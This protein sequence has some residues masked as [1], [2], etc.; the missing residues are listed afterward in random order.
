MITLLNFPFFLVGILAIAIPILL[1]LLMRGRPRKEIFPAFRLIKKTERR[2]KRRLNLRHYLLLTLRGLLFLLL[3]LLLARPALRLIGGS[4]P[5]REEGPGVPTR[6]GSVAAVLVFDTSPRTA[7]RQDN[8]SRLEEAKSFASEILT[9]LPAESRAAVLTSVG[10]TDFFQVDLLAAR[11]QIEFLKSGPEKRR[12]IESVTEGLTLL[13]SVGEANRELFIF[14]DRTAPGWDKELR[15]ELKRLLQKEESGLDCYLIDVAPSRSEDVGLE[16]V[17]P[18][19]GADGEKGNLQL[20]LDLVG[21][22]EEQEGL[23]TLYL[24]RPE[25]ENGEEREGTNAESGKGEGF[26]KEMSGSTDGI[27][28]EIFQRAEKRLTKAFSFRTEEGNDSSV[29]G[30]GEERSRVRRQTISFHL[31]GLDAGFYQGFFQKTPPDNLGENDRIWFTASIHSEN[32]VLLVTPEPVDQKALFFRE[33][34]AP[35]ELRRTGMAPYEVV[36][37]SFQDFRESDFDLTPYRAV[38]FLDVPPLSPSDWKKVARFTERG[39]GVGFFLGRNAS[40]SEGFDQ[41]DALDLLGGRPIRQVR[42]PSGGGRLV[43]VA[44]EHPILSP[45][46]SQQAVMNLPW[47]ELPIFR[48]WRMEWN[49]EDRPV[50]ILRFADRTESEEGDGEED[51]DMRSILAVRPYGEGMVVI[52][53]TPFSDAP[54]D[55][56]RWNQWTTGDA[57]WV[58]LVLADGIVRTLLFGGDGKTD[59]FPFEIMTYRPNKRDIPETVTVVVPDGRRIPIQ[60]D[61]EGRV[62]FVG[63]GAVGPYR[64]L[65]EKDG[66]GRVDGNRE[67]READARPGQRTD[68]GWTVNYRPGDFDPTLIPREEILALFDPSSAVFLQSPDDLEFDATRRGRGID[69]VPL[70]ALLLVIVFAAEMVLANRFYD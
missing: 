19:W 37:L 43:P 14:T 27:D 21:R 24:L 62:R 34:L 25:G 56:D 9:R 52:A 17:I 30:E 46:G 28:S 18:L 44:P 55:P 20:D 67:K 47:E 32:R 49:P 45:F 70:L 15:P 4:G 31:S 59:L 1:H 42:V 53:T 2:S 10:E 22:G 51:S 68:F 66:T 5:D 58:F 60:T 36:T 13:D 33:A 35:E 63:T 64:L 12:L 16:S 3:G 41:P 61:E 57:S 6:T 48:Y 26:I 11:E 50:D 54:V 65:M 29:K 7:Y 40:P 69:L 38:L 23:L 8:R 39:G